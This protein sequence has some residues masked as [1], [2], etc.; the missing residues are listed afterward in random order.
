METTPME[1]A[2]QQRDHLVARLFEANLATYDLATLYLGDRLGLYA[3]LAEAGALTAGELAARTGT[4]ER[5]VREWLEQQ[6]VTGILAV[7]DAQ[8]EPAARRYGVP[9]AHQEVLLDR[10]S[11]NY[12]APLGRF[13][14]G[15]LT[16]L[17]HLLHAFRTGGGVPYP[18]YGADAR[19][20]QAD[21]NRTMF[22]NLLGSEWLPAIPDVH[23][24]LQA[25]PP[26]RV[27]DIACGTGW[28]SIAMARAYPTVRVD[29][30]DAD[31]ASIALA[32]QHAHAE[33]LTD[34]VTFT[35]RDAADPGAHGSY[36]LITIFEAL[37]D[38]PRPVDALRAA[39]RMLKDG[40]AVV[41]ADERVQETFTAP[42]P[43]E[44]LFY[45]WS[46]LFCLPTGMADQPSAGTG[47]VM[48]MDTLRRY[49]SDAGFGAVE[50]VPIQNDFWR[51][52][53]LSG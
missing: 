34:H 15:V 42:N 22:V 19:E 46:V 36:D 23:A 52:Y 37:H 17:P 10:D 43:D 24:R 28:S 38:L 26:A 49:A 40:G 5:Y 6:A 44:R 47:A 16:G 27:A 8:A 33:G 53:R 1:H 30:F 14:M 12:L 13:T 11:L 48:R 25:D 3:A 21:V 9:A 2:T 32:K 39:K 50:V 4:Q 35:V 51:F 18:A 45:A 29:G 20:G 41:I 7:E 31:E